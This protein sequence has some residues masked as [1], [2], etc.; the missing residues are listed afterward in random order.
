MTNRERRSGE[1]ST[2]R[3]LLVKLSKESD[4]LFQ[5]RMRLF[6]RTHTPDCAGHSLLWFVSHFD[7]NPNPSPY[8][9]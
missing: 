5:M 4:E 2:S 1:A 3:R 6:D 7:L 9:A 8:A